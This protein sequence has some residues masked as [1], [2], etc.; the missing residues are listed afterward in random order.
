MIGVSVGWPHCS[1]SAHAGGSE[2]KYPDVHLHLHVFEEESVGE[3][4]RVG[5]PCAGER[6]EGKGWNGRDWDADM[7]PY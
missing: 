5:R 6:G 4:E 7:I 2:T 3:L 1:L